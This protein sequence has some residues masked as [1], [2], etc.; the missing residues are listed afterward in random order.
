MKTNRLLIA[1]ALVAFSFTS[2]VKDELY[3]DDTVIA[4]SDIVINEVFSRGVPGNADWVEVYNTSN[5]PIDLS[6]YTIY[7]GG[8]Q[9][10]AKP[11]MAFPD[12][13][14]V[15]AK[16]FYVITVDI[17][18]PAGF[19]LSSGGDILWLENAE[20]EVIDNVEVPAMPV[21]TTSY[22]R[23][24]DGGATWQILETITKGAANDDSPAPEVS[25]I[26][27]NEVYSRGIDGNLD[28][29]EIHNTSEAEIDIT[30]YKIYD[31]G[32]QSGSKPKK[33]FPSGSVVPANGFL[34]IV[35]DDAEESGFGISS[36]G[37]D[38]WLEDTAGEVIHTV[39]V[40]AI[41]VETSSYGAF[42]DGSTTWQILDFVTRGTANT[43]ASAPS[44]KLNEV[45][46]R[47][48][49]GNL[50]WVELYNTSATDI[51]ISGYK[52]YDSGGFAGTKPKM[53]FAA[54]STITAN[55][56]LVIVV[57]DATT[58]NPVDSDFG[59]SSGGESLWL[60]D[61][62]GNVIDFVTFPALEET[63]SFGRFA[64]GA[65]SWQIIN[66]VTRGSANSDAAAAPVIVMNEIYSRG[67]DVAPDWIEVYNN[68]ASAVD[69][70]GYL[71]YDSG[72][73]AGTKPKKAFPAGS[74]VPANGFLVIVVDDVEDSGFGLSSGG[75]SVWL[76]D[77][78]GNVIDFV[79][80]PAL[81]ET[82]AF[83]RF[84][85]GVH[86]WE[87]LNTITQG[88]ANAQ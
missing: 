26:L 85:D 45:N 8:G 69:I 66:F 46:S 53:E 14:I 41:S 19:G 71:I 51:D 50:D 43:N 52:I 1:I 30:G 54:G 78:S 86:S 88:A 34:V 18:D 80:F 60:E 28:W 20:G 58:A 87:V 13:T 4:D 57:D 2:C 81:E 37:E 49:D 74:I 59:L 27:I 7:D 56:F 31:S 83:G 75:E 82:Q 84:A 48:Y 68:S 24:P 22:G 44:I 21:E 72:G 62:A 36:G 6:G 32:G 47:G 76:E 79:T 17:E 33:E 55:G 63:Q 61:A 42:P 67:T 73:F 5:A 40:P 12:G 70:S 23:M 16:G 3:V 15:P 29:V 9:S 65:H 11:K 38:I 35:V 10:G 77:A 39:T 64:D 25:D